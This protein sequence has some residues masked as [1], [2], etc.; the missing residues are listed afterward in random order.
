MLA[1]EGYIVLS[2]VIL[3]IIALAKEIM[4]PG[5][6][7]FTSAVILMSVGA[8]TND[9]LLAGFSNKGMVTVAVLFLVSEGVRQS[10]ILNRVAQTYLPKKE[11]KCFCFCLVLCCQFQL[12][13]LF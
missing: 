3:T 7:F 8:I 2:V 12:C 11:G 5:L 6:V 4:R 13:Q 9:E 1:F 10:G